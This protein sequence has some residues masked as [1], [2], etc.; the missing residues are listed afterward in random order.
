MKAV[1]QKTAAREIS[2]A[3]RVRNSEGILAGSVV[4]LSRLMDIIAGF[5]LVSVMVLVVANIL[6]RTVFNRPILGTIE[7]VGFLMAAVIGLSLAFCAVQNAHIAV[8]F[9]VERFPAR[10]QAAV[11]VLVNALACGFWGLMAW[12]L[13]VYAGSLAASGVVSSTVQVPYYPFV[14]LVSTGLFTL[15]MVLL[16]RLIE[17]VKKAAE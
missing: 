5:G 8:N 16:T 7:Y 11:D 17:S 9:V 10:M 6:L 12:Q 1:A 14:Y 4:T 2:F 15:S 13:W 3:G